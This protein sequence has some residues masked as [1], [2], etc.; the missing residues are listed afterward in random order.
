[1][2]I[3]RPV[4]IADTCFFCLVGCHTTCLHDIDRLYV[5]LVPAGGDML[6][7]AEADLRAAVLDVLTVWIPTHFMPYV[8][9]SW[10]VFNL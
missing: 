10:I 3:Q 6:V 4:S 1:M 8:I 7:Q 9:I 2:S 5:T